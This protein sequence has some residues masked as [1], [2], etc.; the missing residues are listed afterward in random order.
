MS[1]RNITPPRLPQPNGELTLDYM[2]DLVASLDFFIQQEQ[3]PGEGRNTKLVFTALPTSDVGLEQGTLYRIG[4][5]VKVSL[6]NI[7]GVNGNSSTSS[8]GSVTVSVS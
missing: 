8:V 6:L 1:S 7:A 3:N 4:N 5:D 2:Y